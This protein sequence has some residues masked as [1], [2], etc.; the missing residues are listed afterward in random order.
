MQSRLIPIYL[1]FIAM[2]MIDAVGPMVSL[3]RESFALSITMATMLPLTGYLMYGL[4][5]IPVG[6]LQDRKGKLYI[7]HLGLV[8]AFAGLI[9]PIFA[10]MHGSMKVINSNLSQFYKILLAIL[11]LGAGGSIMQVAGN[12]FIRDVSKKG[13]YS[14]NLAMAQSF[15]TIGSSLGFL[16]PSLMFNVFR[17]DWSILFPV[18]A[19]IIL[20]TFI[21]LSTTRYKDAETRNEQHASIKSCLRLLEKK[22]VLAMVMGIFIYCGVEI[23][24]SSHVPVLL[25]D[26]FHV[27]VEKLGLLISWSLFYL[28]IFVGRF[29]GAFI[30]TRIAPRRLLP[31]LGFISL[32]GII[33]ILFSRSFQVAMGGVL[34]TGLG[35]A[36]IFPL[37]FSLTIERMPQYTN[38]LSGLMVSCVAGGAFIPPIM[39]MVADRTSIT[40]A[41]MVPLMCVLYIIFIG[42]LNNARTA[43]L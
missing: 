41:F 6:L 40:L 19:G 5:S 9:I 28:P 35:F 29:S 8:V 21:W 32:L 37:I 11:L 10:G 18:Y 4:L 14:R 15:I 31:M 17:L 3:A 27:S 36:N 43:N 26:K 1:V 42:I 39:G 16:L 22:Y 38:E 24:I 23:A 30:M 25:L 34:I 13:Q 33:M 2:G 7:L 20:L 12:P